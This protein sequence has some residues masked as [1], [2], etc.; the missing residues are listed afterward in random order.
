[1]G[2]LFQGECML[3]ERIVSRIEAAVRN[4]TN[5]KEEIEKEGIKGDTDDSL[6]TFVCGVVKKAEDQIEQILQE[7]QVITDENEKISRS[8]QVHRNLE[9]FL[10][11]LDLI[12][13]ATPQI[14]TEL[15][16]LTKASLRDLGHEDV[17]AVLIPEA[18]LGTTNLS[19]AFRSLFVFFDNVLSYIS[20][21]FPFYWIIL[22]PPSFIRTPLSWPLIAHEMGHM[23]EKQK[24]QVVNRY[25]P[26]PFVPSLSP[27]DLKSYYAQEF[28]ADF[29]AVSYFGPI[30]A[31]RLLE[32][33]YT[34][35]FM[36]SRTHPSWRE[37]FE[38]IAD[39]LE[40]AGFLA[41]ATDLKEVSRREEPSMIG[42]GSL[43]HLKNILSETETKLSGS[44][45]VYTGDDAEEMK[46]R[47]RLDAFA[48]YTDDIRTLV[49]VADSVLQSK[50]RS[51]SDPAEKRNAERDLDY[52]LIDSIRLNYIKNLVQP[53][54]LDCNSALS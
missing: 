40:E 43:E 15:Y 42:R 49:N 18:S 4:L 20:S 11:D 44:T 26:Y 12:R 46:A 51:V 21:A 22:V 34:R 25:Y 17:K 53:V 19:D 33:Y 28:Q 3:D 8:E 24:W 52:L 50:L 32:I 35:E 54:S 39:K 29:V 36:I 7:I 9:R 23:L 13:T 14:P 2:P 41:E 16:Y 38:A 48:P 37:R 45:C 10:Y 27:L 5:A 47:R 30:F 1:M 6:K 31:R